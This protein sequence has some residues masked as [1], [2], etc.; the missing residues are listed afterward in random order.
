[1]NQVAVHNTRHPRVVCGLK[2]VKSAKPGSNGSMAQTFRSKL[3]AKYTAT[4]KEC[5]NRSLLGGLYGEILQIQEKEIL[6]EIK[7]AT[8]ELLEAKE[9]FEKE[10]LMMNEDG[11]YQMREDFCITKAKRTIIK[12]YR[13]GMM[14]GH[15]GSKQPFYNA[16]K[17]HW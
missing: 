17:R 13:E 5:R 10:G 3:V 8:K 2:M 11:V 15:P 1:M 4:V 6:E 16:A 7:T 9:V 12:L 14:E